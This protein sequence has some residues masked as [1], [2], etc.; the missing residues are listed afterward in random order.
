MDTAFLSLVLAAPLLWLISLFLLRRWPYFR[1]F[2]ICNLVVLAAYLVLIGQFPF[3]HDEYGL[4]RLFVGAGAVAGHAL[5]GFIFAVGLRSR[6]MGK[7]QPC[8]GHV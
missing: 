3:G 2:F 8:H 1:L 6:P 5:L 7:A 4:G